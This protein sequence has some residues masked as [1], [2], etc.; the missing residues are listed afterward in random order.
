MSGAYILACLRL[1]QAWRP[2]C[3]LACQA[4]SSV[5]M[6]QA[7]LI[8][9]PGNRVECVGNRTECALLMMLRNWGVDYTALRE[10]HKP[11]VD[12]VWLFS[13]ATKM[14]AASVARPHGLRLYNKVRASLKLEWL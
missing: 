13:S 1:Q 11:D 4:A 12:K 10:Q 5:H 8:V 6:L 3:L 2:L 7:F 14:S 9:Q